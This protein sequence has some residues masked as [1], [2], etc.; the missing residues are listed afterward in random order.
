MIEQ[1]VV[2]LEGVQIHYHFT[3]STGNIFHILRNPVGLRLNGC[4]HKHIIHPQTG[5]PGISFVGPC[6]FFFG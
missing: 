1:T 6:F 3:G 2:Q 5:L 4:Y